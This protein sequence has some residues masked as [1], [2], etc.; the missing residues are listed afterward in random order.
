MT[1]AGERIKPQYTITALSNEIGLSGLNRD[2][3]R[4]AM[5][6]Q[7]GFRGTRS[8]GWR[9]LNSPNSVAVRDDRSSSTTAS[10]LELFTATP[11]A[12]DDLLQPL[13]VEW[14]LYK[15][16]NGAYA[17]MRTRKHDRSL[18]RI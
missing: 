7:M 1:N 14:K 10:C 17:R 13:L 18:A 15:V 11:G 6:T 2:P 8:L 12:L 5:G 16:I 9:N 4:Y 3:S